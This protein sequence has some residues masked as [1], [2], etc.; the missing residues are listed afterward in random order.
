M[1]VR[2][3]I[4]IFFRLSLYES[5]WYYYMNIRDG[6]NDSIRDK[7]YRHGRYGKGEVEMILYKDK[8]EV[9][10]R[11]KDDYQKVLQEIASF[12]NKYESDK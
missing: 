10:H 6:Q 5:I 11:N 8:P 1:I 7:C 2:K 12:L 3:K 9:K 4:Y